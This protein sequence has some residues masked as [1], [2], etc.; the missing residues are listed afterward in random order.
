MSVH[1]V[2]GHW[3]SLPSDGILKLLPFAILLRTEHHRL[4]TLHL[5]KGLSTALSKLCICLWRSASKV[6]RSV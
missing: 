5:V 3:L 2:V 4:R 1:L 6:K